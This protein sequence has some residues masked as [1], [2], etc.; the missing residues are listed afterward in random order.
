MTDIQGLFQEEIRSTKLKPKQYIS[1]TQTAHMVYMYYR[2]MISLLCIHIYTG[3]M[4]VERIE[5]Q[6]GRDT[7]GRQIGTEN[8]TTSTRF[9]ET[10]PN[11]KPTA[12]RNRL[13]HTIS[14]KLVHHKSITTL[15]ILLR[16]SFLGRKV[17]AAATFCQGFQCESCCEKNCVLRDMWDTILTMRS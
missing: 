12:F 2:F 6:S 11:P 13:L 16:T 10:R 5:Q 9:R 14:P 8:T 7:F 4:H 3:Y 17:K 15:A 1:T